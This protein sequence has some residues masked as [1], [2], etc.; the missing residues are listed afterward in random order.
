MY[1]ILNSSCMFQLDVLI[2]STSYVL[3]VCS[4]C[5]DYLDVSLGWYILRLLSVF[6]IPKISS[7]QL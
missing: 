7:T 4:S 6:T 5:M 2:V 3:V 1:S